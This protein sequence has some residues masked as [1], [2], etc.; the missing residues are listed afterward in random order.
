V[1]QG[2]SSNRGFA[3]SAA[4]LL[5]VFASIAVLGVTTFVVQRQAQA[6]A[7]QAQAKCVYSAQAGVHAALYGY[8]LRDAS[9]NGYFSLGQADTGG[10]NYYVLA[11]SAGDVLI[12]NASAAS[13]GGSS[14]RYVYGVTLQNATNSKSI[15]IDRMVVTWNNGRRLQAVVINGIAVYSGTASSPASI[16]I[17]NFT[18]NA[19]AS[20]YPLTY[21]RFNN[22]MSNAAISVTFVMTDGSS[23]AA[24]VYP[25]SQTAVFS[26]EAT[27]KR[28]DAALSRTIRADYNGLT[29]KIT[30]YRE[31]NARIH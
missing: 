27:G 11:A 2:R 30:G 21:L 26:V 29:S 22:N 17:S 9:G 24:Q 5:I 13:I 6:Q 25:A 31:L 3:L 28:T 20:V 19:N 18:L 16:N 4:I 15:T 23:R 12:V 1:R 7:R 8:R 14:N 10:G